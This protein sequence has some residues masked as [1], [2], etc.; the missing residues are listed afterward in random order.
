MPCSSGV[1]DR[2]RRA[3]P[4]ACVQLHRR[5]KHGTGPRWERSQGRRHRGHR[6][7]APGAEPKQ[8]VRQAVPVDKAASHD[9]AGSLQLGTVNGY[10][11][12]QQDCM[13]HNA[14]C[15]HPRRDQRTQQQPSSAHSTLLLLSDHAAAWTLALCCL[16][17]RVVALLKGRSKSRALKRS[18]QK[19]TT[20]H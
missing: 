3:A 11:G 9:A 15:K 10:R 20:S 8:P 12:A 19:E 6:G 1:W 17:H 18:T 4:A 13:L 2:A 14:L 7:H 16:D 5:R